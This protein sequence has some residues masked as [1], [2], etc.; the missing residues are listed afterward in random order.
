MPSNIG[1]LATGDEIVVGDILN[2][3]AQLMANTLFHEQMHVTEHRIVRDDE[4]N[5]TK[6]ILS[7]LEDN[8][9]LIITGGL[10]PTTD[11]RTR[12]ALAK[13]IQQPLE[14]HDDVWQAIINRLSQRYGMTNIP[15]SNQQQALFPK[16]AQILDNPHGTAAG[17][18]CRFQG[19]LIFMLP[20]PPNECLPMFTHHVFPILQ[21]EKFGQETYFKNWLL[22]GV[23]EGHIAE[24]LEEALASF[25]SCQTG[26]RV[27]FPYLEFK[28][29]SK[30][31]TE[32]QKSIQAV[33]NIIGPYL[34]NHSTTKTSELLKNFLKTHLHEIS[35]LDN[36]TGGWLEQLL[37]MPELNSQLHFNANNKNH[38]RLE[39]SGLDEY[40]NSV[41]DA[42]Q[43]TLHLSLTSPAGNAYQE[44]KTFL[45]YQ[46][47]NLHYAAEYACQFL[48][49]HL[50]NSSPPETMR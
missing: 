24:K 28:V 15:V 29:F 41:P 5:I 25:S 10:G 9:A 37:R 38:W 14:L 1:F 46:Q 35:I 19:K 4:A 21:K 36:A 23:S 50:N 32:L 18:L 13:A 17:C 39:L 34:L 6:N 20:G 33:S 22:F 26:Y 11:D 7:L 30:D 47:R 40:W 44:S 16:E 31:E 42:K 45:N 3:N 48:F 27:T 2:T 49:N 12:F 43:V 8:D